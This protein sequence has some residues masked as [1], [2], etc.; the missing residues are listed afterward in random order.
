MDLTCVILTNKPTKDIQTTLASI[1][2]AD[3]TIT[4]RDLPGT[5]EIGDF[6]AQRNLGLKKA[7]NDWVLFIDDDEVVSPKLA[8]EI[9]KAIVTKDFSGYYLRRLDRFHGQILRHGETGNIKIIRLAKK[10]AGKFVRPVHEVWQIKGNIGKLK[11]PLLHD[12]GELTGPF[13]DRIT[14]YGPID[15]QAL[16]TEGKSFSYWRL[17]LNP[18]AKF[19]LN[20]KLKFGF[21]DGYLGLFHAYLM[22]VQSL[23]VRVFQWQEK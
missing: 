21:L 15:A 17:L 16:A 19:V 9:E 12:R 7:K 11:N 23:S 13:I 2:F 3:E 6:A 4:L 20:Y 18:I 5:R 22:S 14:R 1:G 10:N 8:R